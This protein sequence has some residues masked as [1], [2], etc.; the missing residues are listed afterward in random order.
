MPNMPGSCGKSHFIA[1][2][3]CKT[4]VARQTD[5]VLRTKQEGLQGPRE[6]GAY[7]LPGS[8]GERG[9]FKTGEGQL[10]PVAGSTRNKLLFT[11]RS[12]LRNSVIRIVFNVHS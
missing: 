5:S 3:T 4:M 8:R 9:S 11:T 7:R 1:S 10:W 2:M 12:F 6:R